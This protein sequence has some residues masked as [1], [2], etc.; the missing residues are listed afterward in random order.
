MIL[1]F[2]ETT[3]KLENS[4]NFSRIPLVKEVGGKQ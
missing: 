3:I 4:F 2:N 1:L